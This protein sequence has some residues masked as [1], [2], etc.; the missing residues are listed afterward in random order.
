MLFRLEDKAKITAYSLLKKNEN[1]RMALY[2]LA[3]IYRRSDPVLAFDFL[4]KYIKAKPW[5]S[6]N[7]TLHLAATLSIRIAKLDTSSR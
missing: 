3:N 6:S 1:N 5:L 4:E 7:N 2:T